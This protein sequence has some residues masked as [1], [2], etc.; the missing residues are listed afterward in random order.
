MNKD[1]FW[2]VGLGVYILFLSVIPL[3]KSPQNP[4][5]LDI[6]PL[7]DSCVFKTVAFYMQRGLMPYRDI[8]D[9]KG[10]LIYFYNYLGQTISYWRGIWFVELVSMVVTL[11]LL[12]KIARL[13]CGRFVSC[14]A[15]LLATAPIFGCFD[16]GNFTEEF[17]MPFIAAATLV[18]AKYFLF[19]RV[20]RLQLMACG[21]SFGAVLMLRVNMVLVWAVFCIV[22]LLQ[23]LWEKRVKEL[24]GFIGWFAAGAAILLVPILIWLA[25]N[26]AFEAFVRDYILFNMQY[27]QD[28][29]RASAVNKMLAFFHFINTPIMLVSVLAS[30]FLL[31]QKRDFFHVGYFVYSFLS[32]VLISISGMVYNHYAMILIPMIMYP[33]ASLLAW[34]MPAGEK[35]N[36]SG[37][38]VAVCLIA[39]LALSPWMDGL[40]EAVHMYDERMDMPGASMVTNEIASYIT[41]HTGEDDRIYVTGNRAVIYAKSQRLCASIYPYSE[42]IGEIDETIYSQIDQD[43]RETPPMLIIGE[44]NLVKDQLEQFIT[45]YGYMLVYTAMDGTVIYAIG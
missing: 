21:F 31:Y 41:E 23:C 40:T 38:A 30:A 13:L 44:T 33:I 29:L 8:F 15:L 11:V 24:V 34:V 7:T 10:P 39:V 36:G 43:L 14:G 16:G 3:L 45:E 22:V 26:G 20:S 4:L 35:A 37:G 17:A 25:V 9:H 5:C 28:P 2:Q 12:Y 6:D 19:G 32:F 18:F 27:V 1:R 42:P